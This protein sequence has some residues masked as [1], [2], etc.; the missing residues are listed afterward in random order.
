MQRRI[1]NVYRVFILI[2][3]NP[4]GLIDLVGQQSTR[5][6]MSIPY[7]LRDVNHIHT[8]SG[9]YLTHPLWK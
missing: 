5:I 3:I 1:Y 9:Y 4:L 2:E 6:Q 7:R 8:S